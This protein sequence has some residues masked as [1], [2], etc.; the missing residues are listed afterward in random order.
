M[1]FISIHA[2]VK[3]AT[4]VSQRVCAV[5]A[6]SIHALVKRATIVASSVTGGQNYFNPRP[7]EEGDVWRVP[8]VI[9]RKIF[10]STPS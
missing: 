9:E 3:R 4:T 7:R 5:T 6:I 1:A 8:C 10:Q 2:L